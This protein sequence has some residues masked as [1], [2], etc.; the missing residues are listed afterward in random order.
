[1]ALIQ[2]DTRRGQSLD[3]RVIAAYVAIYLVW[4]STFLA[5]RYAVA[6]LPPL[7]TIAL[8]S[9]VAGGLLFSWAWLRGVARAGWRDWAS[10]AIG[11]FCFFVLCHG[12]LG[13]AEQHIS[14]GLA[15]VI[16][17]LIPVWV[18][19]LDWLRPGGMRPGR[20]TLAGMA[21]SFAGVALLVTP[22]LLA[23]S[24]SRDGLAAIVLM[25]SA[26]AWAA[27]TIFSRDTNPEVA[28]STMASMQLLSGG[29]MLLGISLLSGEWSGLNVRAIEL[30]AVAALAYLI[31][32]GS[33][34][35]FSA[36]L[37]LLRV[38]S[39]ARVAT[40]A[41]VN[42]VVALLLGWAFA[43]EGLASEEVV[44]A[45]IA[46][47]GVAVIITAQHAPGAEKPISNG[48]HD[49]SALARPEDG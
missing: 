2:Q 23:V 27:G 38:S 33:L 17:A 10:A 6:S 31:V 21:L 32:A 18:V 42:P 4:G 20:A 7:L 37:W 14:S 8:R 43:G 34:L 19:I 3:V 24:P 28:P 15:A 26:L 22:D 35:T 49:R 46:V 30:Q 45:L 1:M 9:T 11:G 12:S 47:V 5:L 41:Y 39:P 13:W 16:L 40:Y 25:G 44:A 48:K 36:Y 29:V